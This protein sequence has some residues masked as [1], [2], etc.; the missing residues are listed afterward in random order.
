MSTNEGHVTKLCVP[1][2]YVMSEKQTCELCKEY[3][4]KKHLARV[5]SEKKT[6]SREVHRK[7]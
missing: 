7:N 2:T 1:C 6:E 3:K 4:K 5:M